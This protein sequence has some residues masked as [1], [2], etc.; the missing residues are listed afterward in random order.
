MHLHLRKGSIWALHVGFTLAINNYHWGMVWGESH[1]YFGW[2]Q[3]YPWIP[4]SNPSQYT[5]RAPSQCI[6]LW[7]FTLHRRDQEPSLVHP[8]IHI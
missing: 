1:R 5:H 7:R 4:H 3:G 8:L 6:S 2:N